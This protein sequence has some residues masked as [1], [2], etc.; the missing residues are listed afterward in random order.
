L[1]QILLQNATI[2]ELFEGHKIVIT[3]IGDMGNRCSFGNCGRIDL[4]Q[5]ENTEE[6]MRVLIDYTNHRVVHIAKTDGW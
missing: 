5:Q 6:G 4:H 2:Q 1:L 3:G